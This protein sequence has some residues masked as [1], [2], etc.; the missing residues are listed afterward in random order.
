MGERFQFS[1]RNS[2]L[3]VAWMSVFFAAISLAKGLNDYAR[4]WPDAT[5]AL[6][7]VILML[8][9][10]VSPTFAMGHLT[11]RPKVALYFGAAILVVT[12][13]IL[14]TIQSLQN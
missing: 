9:I 4:S 10:V 3:A 14:K 11:D 13:A 7:A 8:L 12:A 2:L 1:I 6:A 5:R